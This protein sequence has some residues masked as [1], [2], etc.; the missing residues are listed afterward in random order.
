M[1]PRFRLRYDPADD[2]RDQQ[3]DG[4]EQGAV[5]QQPAVVGARD[6]PD[7]VRHREADE[8]DGPGDRGRRAAQQDDTHGAQEPGDGDPLPQP[9][10]D[11][12]AE[13]EAVEP[14]AQAQGQETADDDEGQRLDE[15]VHV[16]AVE[17]A[18][19]PEP[20]LVVRLAVGQQHGVGEGDEQP[21]GGGSGEGE[22]D[23]RGALASEAGHPVDESGRQAGAEEAEPDV[24]PGLG[25]GQHAHREDD[26]DG[27][28]RVDAEQVG[29]AS[30]LRVTPCITVP[31]RPSA[32]PASRPA[33]GQL[34]VQEVRLPR[35]PGAAVVAV[36][37]HRHRSVCRAGRAG[38]QGAWACS[39]S[40]RGRAARRSGATASGC[41]LG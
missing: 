1:T 17:G 26:G 29:S 39:S 12:V 30:G 13:G 6:H 24:L 16:A 37:R 33:R 19:L 20:E 27:H 41:S 9:A 36:M 25:Q 38:G 8:A 14:G 7:R 23:R 32:T 18:D 31:A 21:G 2:V 5:G 28:A 4:G 40:P 3:E 11:V 35:T 22:L 10:G 34:V 15:D